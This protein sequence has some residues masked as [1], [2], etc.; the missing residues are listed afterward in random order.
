M[1][2]LNQLAA[3]Y[4]RAANEADAVIAQRMIGL[5]VTLRNY[6]SSIAHRRS[7]RLATGLYVDGPVRRVGIVEGAI[8]ASVPYAEFE[9]AHGVGH[10][11]AGRTLS[12]QASVIQQWADA[13][14]VAIV[15]Q[16]GGMG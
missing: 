7:G 10:D 15:K 1:P 9:V 14:G 13:M 11:Y 5:L 4:E 12:E 6:A 8:L 16:I 2:D 3:S